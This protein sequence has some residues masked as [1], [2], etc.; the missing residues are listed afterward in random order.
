MRSYLGEEWRLRSGRLRVATVGD[1][2]RWLRGTPLSA[3]VGAGFR[4]RVAVARSVWFACGLGATEFVCFRLQKR[5]QAVHKWMV[6]SIDS[7]PWPLVPRQAVLAGR[8]TLVPTFADGGVSCGRRGGYQQS[9]ISVFW[10]GAPAFLP[11]GS[12]FTQY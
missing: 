6:A 1:P 7:T 12:S 11:S 2:P 9:L 8:R 5:R 10:T 4:R 3:G